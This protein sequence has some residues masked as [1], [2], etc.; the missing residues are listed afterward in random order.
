MPSE[1][2][3]LRVPLGRLLIG[4]LLTVIPISLIGLFALAQSEKSLQESVGTNFRTIAE[5]TSG[6]VS[7][8]IHDRV[9]DVGFMAISPVVVETIAG[10]NRSYPGLGEKAVTDRIQKLET[11]W[12]TPAA[13]QFVK[14]MLSNR[15][16]ALLR[17][18]REMDPRFLRITVTD[19]KGAVVAATHKT[20]DYFQAD[21]DFWQA[22][23]AQGRGG[24]N[25]TDILYDEVTK[26]N[27]IGVGVPVLE[28]GSNRF[29][30]VIDALVDLSSIMPIMNRLQTSR[31][32]K[33]TLAKEDGTVIAAPQATLSMNLKSGEFEAIKDSLGTLGGRQ[34]GHLV[35]AMPGGRRDLIAFADT[36]LKQDYRKLGWLVIVSQDVQEALAPVR[37]IQRLIAFM[38]LV[39]LTAVTLLAVYFALH[40]R[41]TFADIGHVAPPSTRSVSA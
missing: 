29:I 19:E 2:F 1:R 25:L 7:Q 31:T 30:G 17:R 4:L 10:S 41:Q 9:H 33:I 35:V 16:S 11:S 23:C 32:A 36:G 38:A 26:S 8:F 22:V 5:A 3:I 21:E 34:T 27:Y 12:N 20:L 13:D 37:M 18:F 24:I 39:G 28:E 14:A 15:A 40:R 6:E